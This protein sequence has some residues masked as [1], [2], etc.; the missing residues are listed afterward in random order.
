MKKNLGV[1][2]A[3]Y[4]MPVLMVAAL[5]QFSNSQFMASPIRPPTVP[6]EVTLPLNEQSYALTPVPFATRPPA[7]L[8]LLPV[9]VMFAFAEQFIRKM[10]GTSSQPSPALAKP[11]SAAER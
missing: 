1:V 10:E 6:K 7:I 9:V 4:P 11:T 5:K 2:P 3:V 8:L